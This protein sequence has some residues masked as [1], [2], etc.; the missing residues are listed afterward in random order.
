MII[1]RLLI[2]NDDRYIHYSLYNLVFIFLTDR[3]SMSLRRIRAF[4]M[5]TCSRYSGF[6]NRKLIYQ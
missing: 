6:M 2:P 4:H 3:V 5:I 1:I